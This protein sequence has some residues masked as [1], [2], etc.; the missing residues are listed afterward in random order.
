MSMSQSETSQLHADWLA[1]MRRADRYRLA[2][3]RVRD[4]AEYK[5]DDDLAEIAST[6]LADDTD[7]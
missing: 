5:G 4:E 3:M 7:A 2:L 6:A 1:Q